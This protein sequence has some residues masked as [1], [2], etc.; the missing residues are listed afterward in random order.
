MAGKYKL[1]F[2]GYTSSKEFFENLPTDKYSTYI[3]VDYE[4][5]NENGIQV[6]ENIK[7]HGFQFVSLAT[8]QS[9]LLHSKINQVGKEFPGQFMSEISD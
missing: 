1:N 2:K 4:L 7:K 9:D 3:Y 5:G 6:I 8:G